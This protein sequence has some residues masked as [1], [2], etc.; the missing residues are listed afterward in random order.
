MVLVIK[1]QN[2]AISCYQ[3]NIFLHLFRTPIFYRIDYRMYF[4]LIIVC[5]NNKVFYKISE[6]S[7]QNSCER[8]LLVLVAI[9]LFWPTT[10][11][12]MS[13]RINCK[14]VFK[15]LNLSTKMQSSA[16]LALMSTQSM[17]QS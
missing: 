4:V 10:S 15:V 2:T 8:M 5:Y 14:S 11:L 13:C 1:I 6:N 16:D 3:S 7:R 12:L 9:G 17:K